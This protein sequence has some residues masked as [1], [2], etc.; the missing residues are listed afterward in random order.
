MRKL[1]E[2]FNDLSQFHIWQVIETYHRICVAL[3]S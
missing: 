3:N 1:N 2:G